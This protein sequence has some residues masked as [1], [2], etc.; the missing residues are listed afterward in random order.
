MKR[1]LPSLLATCIALLAGPA[2][3]SDWS[4]D[5]DAAFARAAREDRLVIVALYADWC[6]WCRKLEREVFPSERFLSFA[7][8]FVLLR[9]NVEDGGAG[10][11]LRDRHRAG[12][13]PTLLVLDARQV[14]IAE[15]E[16]YL[17]AGDLV[18]EIE[19]GLAA[20]RSLVAASEQALAEPPAPARLRSLA[21]QFHRRDD[22]RRAATLYRRWLALDPPEPARRWGRYLLA[23][24]HQIA[25]DRSEALAELA[26]ARAAAA[27]AGDG[28]LGEL[29]ALLASRIHEADGRCAEARAALEAF[30][31][32]SPANR[33][34]ARVR[35]EIA[36]L[37]PGGP[38]SR[39]G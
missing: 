14:R 23:D 9:A 17:P 2:L 4:T 38:A 7:R 31:A 8:P 11:A 3:A 5:P 12:S 36:R 22:G 21:E 1:L 24:A 16:G 30:L 26:R 32:E 35:G 28:E 37:A 19:R 25:G 39:C 10:S 6:G 13:L 18:A 34:S 29:A 20:W 27:A 33:R 15:V